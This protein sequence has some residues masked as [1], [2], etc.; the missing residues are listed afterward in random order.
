[1]SKFVDLTGR[2]FG[3]WSVLSY[4]PDSRLWRC[5]CDC[6]KRFNVPKKHLCSGRSTKCRQCAG[7][8][9]S[10]FEAYNLVG[11]VV[12]NRNIISFDPQKRKFSLSCECGNTT[13]QN[14]NKVFDG[15]IP[16][17]CNRCVH[18]RGVGDLTSTV[19]SRYKYY[20]SQRGLSFDVSIDFLWNLFLSQNKQ[21]SYSGLLLVLDKTYTS[22]L[23]SEKN[24]ASL[25][26]IDPQIGYEEGNVHWI[27]KRI[28]YMKGNMS[29]EEFLS[30][31]A[32]IFDN[33]KNHN[34]II[35]LSDPTNLSVINRRV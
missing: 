7:R 30:W 27:H 33:N 6:G 26:R 21:C 23:E 22:A 11:S 10:D 1:M 9:F 14:I 19:Y 12:N 16:S 31:C 28:N 29:H 34:H 32:V 15:Q 3:K 17:K 35:D 2:R 20:A 13:W 4:I 25:D 8:R 18:W 5:Q 24:T